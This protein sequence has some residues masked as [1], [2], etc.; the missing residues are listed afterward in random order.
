MAHVY[1]TL[2][3]RYF[4]E[5]AK[6]CSRLGMRVLDLDVGSCSTSRSNSARLYKQ[7][8]LRTTPEDSVIFVAHSHGTL[9]V[10][11]LL[12]D[13]QYAVIHQRVDGFIPLNGVFQGSPVLSAL[14]A[15]PLVGPI[16]NWG[17]GLGHHFI[18]G[19]KG[20]FGDMLTNACST[21]NLMRADDLHALR[22]RTSIVSLV[23]SYIWPQRLIDLSAPI[24]L[25]GSLVVGFFHPGE[26]ND[27]GLP[28]SSQRFMGAPY[29][30][31]TGMHHSATVDDFSSVDLG[32]MMHTL[33]IITID[34]MSPAQRSRGRLPT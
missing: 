12:C 23:T 8:L 16:I 24:F 25:L 2:G 3:G 10:R 27:G 30:R 6:R 34:G 7:L 31:L 32:E 5:H 28:E 33:L 17:C 15:I 14:L 20:T 9:T 1:R 22:A 26:P 13:P 4:D 11:D 19:E 21:Y 29:V 18:S